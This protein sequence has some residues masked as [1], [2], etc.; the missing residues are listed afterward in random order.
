M[1]RRKEQM[2]ETTDD[3]VRD[4]TNAAFK[5]TD[6]MTAHRYEYVTVEQSAPASGGD[7]KFARRVKMRKICKDIIDRCQTLSQLINKRTLTP[8][9]QARLAKLEQKKQ[10]YE[11]DKVNNSWTYTLDE[12]L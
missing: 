5:Q 3:L 7:E 1:A 12:S 11:H 6:D 2:R 8:V 10:V 4:V 9:E